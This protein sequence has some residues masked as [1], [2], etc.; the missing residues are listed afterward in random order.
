MNTDEKLDA[1]LRYVGDEDRVC[2]KPLIWNALW[3]RLPNR[4]RKG[5]GW[6]PPAPLILGA[7]HETSDDE[8]ANR[9]D[10]HI[11]HAHQHAAFDELDLFIRGLDA[12]SW[13]YRGEV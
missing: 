4:E 13:V 8:K 1:L 2:P 9:L 10:L 6:M 7:W 11:R 3:E 5:F 12:D